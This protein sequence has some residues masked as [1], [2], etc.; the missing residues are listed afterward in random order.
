M[1][2]LQLIILLI[3]LLVTDT[4]I[5]FLVPFYSLKLPVLTCDPCFDLHIA[6]QCLSMSRQSIAWEVKEGQQGW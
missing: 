3:L 5:A 1:S 6:R 2:W 4:S